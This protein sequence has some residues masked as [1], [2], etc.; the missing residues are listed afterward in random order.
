[1]VCYEVI[2]P[3]SVI[4]PKHR[5]QLLLNVTNDAWFGMSS[6]PYQHFEMSR[7]RAVEQGIPLVRVANTGITA[8][9]DSYGRIIASLPLGAK[10][11][12]DNKLPKPKTTYITYT[13]YNSHTIHVA[14][15]LLLLLLLL[16]VL[17][18]KHEEN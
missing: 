2:F 16:I 8:I 7:M 15:L 18:R 13:T 11:F 6:G 9:I 12:I 5:P 10:G 1:L 3:E 17:P 4:D 14:L